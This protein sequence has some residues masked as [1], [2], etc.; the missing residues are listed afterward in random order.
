MDQMTERHGRLIELDSLR[1]VAALAVAFS[2]SMAVFRIDGM[3]MAWTAPLAERS[4]GGL[5]VGV[6]EA[7]FNAQAAVVLFFVLSGYVL[8]RSIRHGATGETSIF[9][10]LRRRAFRILP[11]MWISLTVAFAL[12]KAIRTIPDPALFSA[13]YTGCFANRSLE[14]LAMNFA[15]AQTMVSPVTWTMRIEILGSL[16]VPLF[17]WINCHYSVR[18]RVWCGIIIGVMGAIIGSD[19]SYMFAFYIGCACAVSPI[20]I[21]RPR[22]VVGGAI[23]AIGAWSLLPGRGQPPALA[24]ILFTFASAGIVLSIASSREIFWLLKTLPVSF[25]G[26]IS[27]SFYLFHSSALVVLTVLTLPWLIDHGAIA[28]NLTL[29]VGSAALTLPVAAATYLLIEKPCIRMGRTPFRLLQ[30]REL[31]AEEALAPQPVH[32]NP[33]ASAN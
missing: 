26:R 16:L 29:F 8:C 3:S 30:P 25:L 21:R 13:W 19:T 5:A 11:V 27:Y 17:C 33:T 12:S 4:T 14:D 1:G 18:G 10:F 22:A 24:P 23:L 28:A 31:M 32:S 15:L 9:D 2:H 6:A 7:L 20:T